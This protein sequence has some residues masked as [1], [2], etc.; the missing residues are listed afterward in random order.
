MTYALGE[1]VHIKVGFGGRPRP[2]GSILKDGRSISRGVEK[3]EKF[4]ILHI[5]SAERLNSGK[6]TFVGE[7]EVGEDAA[8]IDI[9]ITS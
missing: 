4:V 2:E 1:E 6:Y 5:D 7:N 3:G 8:D 9:C